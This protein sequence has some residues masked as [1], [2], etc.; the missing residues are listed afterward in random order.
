MS[1]TPEP[2][3]K[4]R[5]I[6][7][8]DQEAARY[9]DLYRGNR[10]E[11]EVYPA[12][13]VRLEIIVARLRE[14]SVRT[15]L[16][17]GCG[18][19]GPLVRLLD[20]G[21]DARGVDFS[22]G[23]VAAA[24]DVLSSAGHDPERASHGDV[25]RRETLP[26]GPFDAIVATGVFPHNLDDAAAYAS[27]QER[28]APQ[29]VALVEYRN[30]LM[31][32]FSLNRYSE[33]FF[34]HDLIRGDELP[35]PLREATRAYL[36]GTLDTPVESVGKPREIEYGDILARFHNP[37]TLGD[38]LAARG[39]ALER[40][41]WYHF[42]AAPPALEREHRVQFWERSL[43]LEDPA[44]WRGMFLASAFVAELRHA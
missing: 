36:A 8:Y 17:I 28:L 32:L 9:I 23:M 2:S 1:N 30:A 34:W 40:I 35:E 4:Q 12:N 14:L 3:E 41:H 33:P 15:V 26:A 24:R 16:D 43:D 38:E 27:L 7:Y 42:H 13:D 29:G 21:F 5:V 6:A 20:E 44:D 18:S 11:R 10:M 22:E 39:L 19:A 31:S 25:E 37:L